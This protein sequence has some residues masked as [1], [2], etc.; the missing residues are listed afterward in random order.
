MSQLNLI[1]IS[2]REFLSALRNSYFLQ[3]EVFLEE[4]AF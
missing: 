3:N 2:V 1:I 4:G